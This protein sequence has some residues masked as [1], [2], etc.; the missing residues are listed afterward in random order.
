M[1]M[2]KYK[3][4]LS[5]VIAI[6]VIFI[7]YSLFF[8]PEGSQIQPIVSSSANTQIINEREVLI[9]LEDL[10]S[11]DLNPELFESKSFITLLDFSIPIEP[12]P[13]GRENPFSS[14]ESEFLFIE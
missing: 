8:K 4:I 10:R 1:D 12:E 5:I 6:I 14:V 13:K 9:L 7:I 2:S 3:K 11:I